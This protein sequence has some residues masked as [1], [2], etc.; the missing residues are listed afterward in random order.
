MFKS[1]WKIVSATHFFCS[2]DFQRYSRFLVR[3]SVSGLIEIIARISAFDSLVRI[4][5]TPW[6]SGLALFS[7][8]KCL[9]PS[10]PIENTFWVSTLALLS[11]RKCLWHSCPDRNDHFSSCRN[12]PLGQRLWQ[13]C[14][15]EN[16]FITKWVSSFGPWKLSPWVNVKWHLRSVPLALLVNVKWLLGVVSLALTCPHSIPGF[17]KDA[18]Y[19]SCIKMIGVGMCDIL[20]KIFLKIACNWCIFAFELKGTYVNLLIWQVI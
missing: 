7:N 1:H 9:W 5:M 6:I 14:P 16:D 15:I 2:Q 12:G 8:R 11:N 18:A 19:T 17:W 20:W 3:F 13:S 4:E 10:C